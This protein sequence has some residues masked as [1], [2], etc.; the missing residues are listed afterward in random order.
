MAPVANVVA[1]TITL[2][3]SGFPVFAVD[4]FSAVVAFSRIIVRLAIFV[5]QRCYLGR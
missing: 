1:Q 2:V 5:S 4:F 3:F